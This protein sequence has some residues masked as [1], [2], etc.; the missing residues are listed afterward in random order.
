MSQLKALLNRG[1]EA[2]EAADPQLHEALEAELRR[3]RHR[4]QLVASSSLVD[5]SVLASEASVAVNVTAEGYPSHRYHGGCE[6][7]DVIERIAIDRAK[8]AFRAQYANV[9]PHS[10]STANLIVMG[11]LLNPGDTLLGLSLDHGGHLSHGSKVSFS[12]RY[13]NAVGYGTTPEGLIDYG[14]VEALAQ[15]HR[16]KLI[17]CG[18]TA[19]SR[20][21]DFER[22]RRIADT[23]GAWL[24]ADIAHIGGLVVAGEHPSPIDVAHITTTCTHKQLFGPRGGLILM[25]KD[26]ALPSPRGS[27]TLAD[28]AQR[29][30]FPLYQGAPVLNSIAARARTLAFVQT[31]EFRKV[32]RRIREGAAILAEVL[33]SRGWKLVAGG[34]DTHIVLMDLR[35]RGLTGLVAE[36]ALEEC[37]F[38]TNKNRIPGDPQPAGIGSGLRLGTNGI[39]RRG[40]GPRAL[41]RVGELMDEVLRNTVLTSPTT[42][43]LDPVL[44]ER[45]RAEVVELC[46]QHPIPGY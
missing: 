44:R 41:A 33:V 2:L 11:M 35:E 12:G 7:V 39:A 29:G 37:Y 43:T 25:G 36:R 40:L 16:P 18:T 9:Q 38:I 20:R 45:V 30:V 27:G 24:L 22:F 34:T 8:Q 17:I 13:Y 4:L 10:A 5:P 1:V 28:A 31:E 32:A 19:Y 14:Q 15:Q 3:Q 46:E 6:G 21:V 26:H 42:Y 23:V